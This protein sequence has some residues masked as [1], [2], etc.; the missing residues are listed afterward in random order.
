MLEKSI[1]L[2]ETYNKRRSYRQFN[3]EAVI[4]IEVIENCIKAAATAPSGANQQGYSFVIVRDLDV[5]NKIRIQAEL[6]EKNFYEDQKN[7]KWHEDL[8]KLKT[9][10][11]KPFLT[12][13]SYLIVIYYHNK[14]DE[15]GKVYYPMHGVGLASGMLLSALN[16]VGL[17]SLTYTPSGMGFLK[18][19]FSRK[20]FEIPYMIVAVGLGDSDY[21]LPDIKRKTKEELIDIF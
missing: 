17:Q 14:T 8:K 4:D 16:Q 2:F 19:M 1:E 12:E 20:S 3:P 13:A 11:S 6:N 15:G 10:F 5:K 21:Q 9:D 18:E 7:S